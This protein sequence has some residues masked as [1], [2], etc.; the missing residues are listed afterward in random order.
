MVNAA[1]KEEE[2]KMK[3]TKNL[4]G[5]AGSTISNVGG[6]LGN[7]Y[8]RGYKDLTV[9]FDGCT[10]EIASAAGTSVS[11]TG[12]FV[13]D[14]KDNTFVFTGENRAERPVRPSLS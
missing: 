13:G 4:Y 12:A 2:P 10:A 3:Q 7:G 9:T 14:G 11:D 5:Q 6:F 8:W 1:K